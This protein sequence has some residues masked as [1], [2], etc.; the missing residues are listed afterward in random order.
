MDIGG[1]EAPDLEAG[2]QPLEV[3]AIFKCLDEEGRVGYAI[4]ETND[5]SHVE[6]LGML[7]AAV[8]QRER[9]LDQS[10]TGPGA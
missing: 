8:S 10:W 1:L 9:V 2:W 6:A 5:V 4:R 3:V 7:A